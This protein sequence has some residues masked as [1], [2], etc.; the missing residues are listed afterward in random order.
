MTLQGPWLNSCFTT[1]RVLNELLDHQE[2]G[3]RICFEGGLSGGVFVFRVRSEDDFRSLF[4]REQSEL[5][6]PI[7]ADNAFCS[8]FIGFSEEKVYPDRL[9][10]SGGAV[11]FEGAQVQLLKGGMGEEDLHGKRN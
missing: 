11:P 6:E 5:A 10:F 3:A 9:A 4:P 1:V 2:D 7:A 8:V